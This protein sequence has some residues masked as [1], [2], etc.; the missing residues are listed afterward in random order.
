MTAYEIMCQILSY[1]EINSAKFCAEIGVN[2]TT[3]HDMK[4]GKTKKIS[5]NLAEKIIVRYPEISRIWLLTGEGQML[6]SGSKYV[7]N[8]N[9]Q[10][11]NNYQGDTVNPTPPELYSIITSQQETIKKQSDQIDRLLAIIEQK[12]N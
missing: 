1:K 2:P 6:A 8:T 11:G 9:D 5:A 12:N 10:H 7:I 4:I 3:I